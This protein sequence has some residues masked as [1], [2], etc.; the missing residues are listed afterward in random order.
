MSRLD[1][2]INGDTPSREHD[3]VEADIENEFVAYA[4]DRGCMALK[5]RVDGKNGFPDR[6]ILCPGGRVLLI[7]FKTPRGRLS[8]LQKVWLAE[9]RRLGFE[10]VV[11]T[12]YEHAMTILDEF[13]EGN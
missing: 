3:M 4:I 7:E 12:R 2:I 1:D 11:S 6:T 13:L 8:L 10:A 5:L 9:L